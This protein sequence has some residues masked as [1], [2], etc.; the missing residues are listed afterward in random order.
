MQKET[1]IAVSSKFVV[2][3]NDLIQKS[4]FRLSLQ[5]QKIILYV[6]SQIS[7]SD[8]EMQT[9]T[10]NIVDF[11]RI[12]GLD[13]AGGQNY[14]SLKD[15]LQEL[16]NK[17]LWISPDPDTEVLVSWLA[18]AKIHK[19][20]GTVE[21]RLDSDLK[22]Y[23]LELKKNFTQYELVY[24]LRMK[25]KVSPRL[26]ELLKSYHYDKT[27]PYQKD[28]EFEELRKLLDCETSTYSRYKD[29]NK[30]VLKPCIKEINEQTDISISYNPITSGRHTTGVS[31]TISR[32]NPIET[33]QATQ[34]TD[35]AFIDAI[36]RPPEPQK[37]AVDAT[38]ESK[39]Q[40]IHKTTKKPVKRPADATENVSNKPKRLQI[41]IYKLGKKDKP[42]QTFSSYDRSDLDQKANKWLSDNGFKTYPYS[43]GTSFRW[44]V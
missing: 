40:Q 18:Y 23:L 36:S 26:Y 24:T 10:F 2:K 16:K 42:I 28:F 19:N 22:P 34:D 12:C 15:S 5:Q 38:H 13:N 32:R 31:F 25:R 6:V 8:H 30:F 29:L 39:Q 43:E 3:S 7:P 37:Q 11:C 17:S 44:E 27:T 9:Y 21:L 35:A 20:S 14:Q 1:Y 33:I 4:R 41:R